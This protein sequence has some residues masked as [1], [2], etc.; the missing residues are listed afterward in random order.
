ML[1]DNQIERYSRQIIV[2]GF[3]G[4]GQER[5]LKARLLVAGTPV[6]AGP[7]AYLSGAGVG[8]V[9]LTGWDAAFDA[10]GLLSQ[11][12]EAN[13]DSA[14]LP[15]AAGAPLPASDLTLAFIASAAQ[16]LAAETR[17]AARA[18]PFLAV[19]LDGKPRLAMLP[20]RPPCLRCIGE[21]VAA[22]PAASSA[23]ADF[24]SM[25]A[26]AEALKLLALERGP[27][28]P[29]GSRLLDFDG[30]SS[31]IRPVARRTVVPPC[32]CAALSPG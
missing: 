23:L 28:A 22:G 3:G 24:A 9:Y 20:T 10:P 13:A 16:A 6:P 1:S 15:L 11:L 14:I 29:A 30:Y 19:W 12:H 17:L 7:L 2:A 5:L 27:D 4:R 18:E 8:T 25:V 31:R 26:C 21:R 32:A